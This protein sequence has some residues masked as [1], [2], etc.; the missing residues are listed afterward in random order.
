MATPKAIV[1]AYARRIKS[2]SITL[3][4]IKNKATREDVAKYLES[5]N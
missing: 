2:G 1:Q 4:D 3:E 5:E